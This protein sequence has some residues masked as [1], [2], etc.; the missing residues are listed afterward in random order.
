M[1]GGRGVVGI[2]VGIFVAACCS[3]LAF[4]QMFA[5]IPMQTPPC[6]THYPQSTIQSRLFLCATKQPPNRDWADIIRE[7]WCV[8]RMRGAHIFG[9]VLCG[10]AGLIYSFVLPS[11]IMSLVGSPHDGPE[12]AIARVAALTE[13]VFFDADSPTT[14][15]FHSSRCW[16]TTA[17]RCH[18][19]FLV[20][21]LLQ[22]PIAAA[23]V[24][25]RVF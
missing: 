4:S 3:S 12:L 17:S 25:S 23:P 9:A 19:S 7:F 21:S 13:L 5:S 6:F 16:H 15:S 18:L 22:W 1:Q 24:A 10:I 20:A 14:V 2:L 11:C 8:K